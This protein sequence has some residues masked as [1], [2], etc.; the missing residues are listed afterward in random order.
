MIWRDLKVLCRNL[1]ASKCLFSCFRHDMS[2]IWNALQKWH[3]IINHVEGN[4]LDGIQ[5]PA[6]IST[7][8]ARLFK[9]TSAWP[10]TKAKYFAHYV[11]QHHADQEDD[12]TFW[13]HRLLYTKG[14]R[15]MNIV[16][17]LIYLLMLRHQ[18]LGIADYKWDTQPIVSAKA[19]KQF[20]AL[21]S[22][23]VTSECIQGTFLY[24]T[25]YLPLCARGKQFS[26]RTV[27]STFVDCLSEMK[28]ASNS[29]FLTAAV[30]FG[31][32]TFVGSPRWANA[33][34]IHWNLPT[35]LYTPSFRM[36]CQ[37]FSE[38]IIYLLSVFQCADL[39]GLSGVR[40][41]WGF[42]KTVSMGGVF[43]DPI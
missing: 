25:V 28:E 15:S 24:D 21:T 39:S 42:E 27:R 35:P 33:L 11:R 43:W 2:N 5:H 18:L 32:E 4:G 10:H 1:A 41:C 12:I 6:S 17:N 14:M 22:K 37:M 8:V 29:C 38:G 36:Q 20:K 23:L 3:L 16:Q 31:L 34:S 19:R 40:D 9:V 30:L 7:W 13:M 26:L